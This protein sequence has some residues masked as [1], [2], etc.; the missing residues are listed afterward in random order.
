MHGILGMTELALGTDLNPEQLEYME[1]VKMSAESLMNIINDILDFSKIEAKK[2]EI[3]SVSFNFHDTINN[4]VSTLSLQ[5]EAKG[6][7][8][9]CRIP[10]RVPKRVV[11]DPGRLRQVLINLL[12]NAIKFTDKGEVVVS[13]NEESK[14]EEDVNFHFSVRDTGIGIPKEKQRVIFDPFSQADGSTTRK[15]GGSGLGLAITSQLVELMGGKIWIEGEVEKGSTFHFTVRLGKYKGPEEKLEPMKFEDVKG[16]RVLVVDD[17]TANRRNLKKMLSFWQ[18][19]S[20]VLACAKDALETMR[21]AK[22][23]DKAFALAIINSEMPE[24]DGFALAEH[25]KRNPDFA[26]TIIMMLS[27]TGIRGD[28]T[29][30]R[31]LGISAYLTKPFKQADLLEAIM[32]ALGTSLKERDDAA[33]ITRH[34]LRESRKRLRILLAEDNIVNQ[35]MA[36]RILEKQGHFVEVACDGYEVLS[37]IENNSFDIILMDVQM[38]KMDGFEATGSIRKNEKKTGKHIPIIAMTAHAMKGDRER[39]L[40]VGMDDYIA[41][42]LKL[43]ELLEVIGRATAKTKKIMKRL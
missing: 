36:V 22:S 38:P 16:L 11:G 32:F 39:C 40:K 9:V 13:V 19:K 34:S 35:K 14:T 30:C 42:P 18:M 28:A 23:T 3:E 25:I 4:I 37:V 7:E 27:S 41:K 20:T 12:S 6:L 24:M 33:L 5:A 15:Y 17:N 43:E 1:A 26:S 8:L 31:K 10:P 21:Q 29:C 2:I